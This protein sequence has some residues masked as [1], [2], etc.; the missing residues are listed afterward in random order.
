M[1]SLRVGIRVPDVEQARTFYCGLGFEEVGTIP[2]PDGPPVLAILHWRGA[3]L[4]LEALDGMPFQDSTR[5]RQIQEGPR[6][7]GVAIGMAVDD[8]VSVYE[9]CQTHGCEI[10]SEP[11]DEPYGDRV[12]ECFDPYGYLWEFSMPMG[13]MQRRVTA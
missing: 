3:H 1:E 6:G 11:N 5:E 12:F 7:L 9:Y 4:I 2:G 8:L 10:T 13:L